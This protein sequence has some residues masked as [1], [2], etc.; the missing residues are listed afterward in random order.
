M[1]RRFFLVFLILYG[2]QAARL[3]YGAQASGLPADETYVYHNAGRRPAVHTES[4]RPAVH[5]DKFSLANKQN[6]LLI[7]IDTVRA[8]HLGCYGYKQARTPNLDALAGQ[9]LFFENAISSVPLTLPS[10]T[11]L[12]T[13]LY[14]FHHE[15]HDNAGVL[16][17]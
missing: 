6:L 10:H 7:T 15:V 17:A 2:P 3:H 13:G 14:P 5:T 8:D 1:F 12:L 4:R 11:T 9:S 16:A